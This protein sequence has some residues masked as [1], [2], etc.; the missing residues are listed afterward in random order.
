MAPS[1]TIALAAG[2][3]A[4]ALVGR[5]ATFI[6]AMHADDRWRF[7]PLALATAYA[8]QLCLEALAASRER[9]HVHAT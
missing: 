2:A 7:S 6:V 3:I 8:C 5:A 4:F 9:P 1:W